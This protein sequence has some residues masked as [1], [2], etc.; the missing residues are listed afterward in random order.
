MVELDEVEKLLQ[1][2]ISFIKGSE[3]K[4][5]T[6]ETEDLTISKVRYYTGEDK[7]SGYYIDYIIENK[8]EN[9]EISPD[10]YTFSDS[11]IRNKL[12]K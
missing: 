3:L 5:Y 11:Y 9:W 7:Q 8:V 2:I 4:K 10:L 6:Y 1:D 12:H